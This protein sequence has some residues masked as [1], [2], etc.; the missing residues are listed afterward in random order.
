MAIFFE[1]CFREIYPFRWETINNDDRWRIAIKFLLRKKNG[2]GISYSLKNFKIYRLWW[3]CA[4]SASPLFDLA[5]QGA[6]Y[7]F[8]GRTERTVSVA[9]WIAEGRLK[10]KTSPPRFQRRR[11]SVRLHHARFATVRFSCCSASRLYNA[12]GICKLTYSVSGACI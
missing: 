5:S 10:R 8:S 9:A 11:N 3:R 1:T 12:S 4:T 7:S 6:S 2:L